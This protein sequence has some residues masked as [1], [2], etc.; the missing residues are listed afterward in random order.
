MAKSLQTPHVPKNVLITGG[1][2]FIGSNFVNFIH[3]AWPQANFV[4]VDKLI[5]DSDLHNINEEV[6]NS[7]RFTQVLADIRNQAA[8]GKVL[9][10]YQIDT[11]IHLA[12]D[13]TSTRCYGET[14]EAFENNVAS[15][16]YFLDAVKE[17]G[18]IVKFVHISTDEVYGDSELTDDEKP[19]LENDAIVKPGNPYAATKIAGEAYCHA[20]RVQYGLPIV[21]VRINN[22]YGP[23][24]WDVKVVPRFIQIAKAQGEFTIQGSGKQLRSWLFVDDASAGLQAVAERGRVGEIYN[25]GTYF[26]KNVHDLA[27]CIQAEVDRQLGRPISEARFKSIPDRPY[28]DMR[29]LIGIEKANVELGWKP[30]IPFE[31]GMRR[32]IASELQQRTSIKMR[33]GIYGGKGYVGGELIK[34]LERRKIPCVLAEKKVGFDS[35]QEVEEELSILGVTHVVCVTGRTSGG[36]I[37]TIEYLE[38]G[39]DKTHINIRDNLYSAMLL[40]HLSRKYGLHYTY[41]GTGYVFSYDKEHPVGSGKGF[42]EEDTPTFFGSSYSVVKG[43]TDRQ[44]GWESINARITLPLSFDTTQPR[45]LLTKIVNYKELFDVPVSITVLPDCLKALVSLMEK[46]YGGTLNLVN[47]EPISLYEIVKLY[48]EIVDPS[49]D[50]KPIDISSERGQQLLNTKGNCALDTTRLESLTKIPTAKESI[51]KYFESIKSSK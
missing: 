27:V 31:E 42:K 30:N 37:N 21:I 7:E 28:N 36:G 10:D 16:I 25:L 23:N 38:G 35:D 19:K 3:A 50:P 41:I 22:V 44:K 43:F 47:P 8:I 6:H 13:C 1:C 51:L 2:G 9:K 46:R 40:A 5:L 29:Y 33:V 45:N 24:Q 11:V 17:Y 18:K 12:A 48:K 32:T 4:N 39:P 49:L 15:F 34:E 26:E 14:R 20:Y